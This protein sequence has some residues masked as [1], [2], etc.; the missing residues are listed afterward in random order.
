M[1]RKRKHNELYRGVFRNDKKSCLI[2]LK[3]KEEREPKIEM[4]ENIDMNFVK[5]KKSLDLNLKVAKNLRF[6]TYFQKLREEIVDIFTQED[7]YISFEGLFN[8]NK[9]NDL[10]NF[11]EAVQ[12]TDQLNNLHTTENRSNNYYEDEIIYEDENETIIKRKKT[13]EKFRD[14]RTMFE[15]S[16]NI[17]NT[18]KSETSF[19]DNLFCLEQNRYKY[20]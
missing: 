18:N 3:P 19:I 13:V 14:R 8:F 4:K 7:E 9:I 16:R 5:Q 20:N 2:D 11:K 17:I 10:F 1:N 12:Q 15:D 6:G